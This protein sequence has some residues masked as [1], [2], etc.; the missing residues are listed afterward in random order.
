MT[1]APSL[2]SVRNHDR[3]LRQSPRSWQEGYRAGQHRASLADCPYTIG[4]SESW[5]WSSGYIE[6]KAVRLESCQH[7]IDVNN[8]Y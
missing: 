5:S 8:E 4:T 6:G 7:R 3:I 1:I 2:P